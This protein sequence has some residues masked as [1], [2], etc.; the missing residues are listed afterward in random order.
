M[1]RFRS[2]GARKWQKLRDFEELDP[3]AERTAPVRFIPA[4]RNMP[5]FW[6]GRFT[7]GLGVIWLRWVERRILLKSACCAW[8]TLVLLTGAGPIF[9]AQ[10]S[11]RTVVRSVQIVVRGGLTIAVIEADGPLPLPASGAVD[12]PPRIYLDLIDVVPQAA[13]MTRLPGG[14]GV[15]GVRVALHAFGPHVTRVVLDLTQPTA[16]WI[17]GEARQAGRIEI[18]IGTESPPAA[19]E[20]A[21]PGPTVPPPAPMPPFSSPASATGP[22]APTPPIGAPVP[23]VPRAEAPSSGG[24]DVP[25]PVPP[26]QT[27]RDLPPAPALPDLRLAPSEIEQY[28]RQLQGALE[29]ILSRRSIVEAIDTAGAVPL[30]VLESTA[31]EFRDLRRLLG[32]IKPS[33]ALRTTHDLLAVSCT[34]G[35]TAISLQIQATRHNDAE[36]RQNAPSAAAGALMLLDRACAR[37]DCG[38]VRP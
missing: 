2:S 25:S 12:G 10:A 9:A 23:A 6:E 3:S 37:L 18:I 22:P 14:G 21:G 34:L 5:P 1:G 16:F 4:R 32:A 36:A 29:R 27:R 31:A 7:P 33:D 30:A 13:R 35:A 38:R 26:H 17:N 24:A 11:T 20:G 19:G 8:F 15:R 28:R